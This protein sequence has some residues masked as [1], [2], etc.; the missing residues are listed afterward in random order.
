MTAGRPAGRPP[1][2]RTRWKSYAPA[3]TV[4]RGPAACANASRVAVDPS[5]PIWPDSAKGARDRAARGRPSHHLADDA[6]H[7]R[8]RERP[9]RL[10]LDVA[11][12]GDGERERRHALVVG[13]L[14]HG[15]DIVGAE[16]PIALL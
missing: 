1:T 4:G 12:L 8:A 10:R 5:R 14:E 15:H 16:R 7:V 11:E 2:I 13:R 3:K 9:Q 6:G